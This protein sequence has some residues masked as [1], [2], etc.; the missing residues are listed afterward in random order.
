[1]AW[2]GKKKRDEPKEIVPDYRRKFYMPPEESKIITT[3][4]DFRIFKEKERKKLIWYEIL[5]QLAGKTIRMKPDTKTRKELESA[6]GFTGLQI[7]PED[8]MALII[9]TI[10]AFVFLTVILVGLGIVSMIASMFVI[11]IGV[12]IAYYF[13]KYPANLLKA[14]RIEASSQVVLAT[15]YMVV[16]MR[17]SPNLENA[18]R[19]AASNITGPLA[20]DMRRVIWDIEMGKYY[21]AA[22]AMTDYIAKWKAENEEFA[23][24]LRLIRDSRNQPPDRGEKVLDEALNIILDGTKVRMKHYAQDLSMP[25]MIIHMMGIVLPVLGSIM[26]PLAAIFLSDM[27]RPEYLFISYDVVLP[28]VIIWFINNTLKKR[29]STFSQV[30]I[31]KHP[32]VP[33]KGMFGMRMGKKT[34]MVPVLPIAI[35]VAF[36]FILPSIIFFSSNP[37]LLTSSQGEHTLE[38]LLMS[39]LIT[40]GIGLGLATYFI[41]SNYQKMSIQ[42][43]IYSIESE[44]ELALFQL[45]NRMSGGTPAE[46]AL[47]KSID[48]VKDLKISGLFTAAL[49][50]I[51]SL[52]ATFSEAFFH[53]KWGATKYYPS[54]LIENIMYMIVDIS[55]KGFMYAADGMLTVS[56]YLRNIRETQEYIRE[57]LSE[58][59]SSMTF[60]A[61]ILTP[62]ITGLIV[63]MS[64]VI[65]VVL[66]ILGQR[67]AALSSGDVPMDISGGLFGFGSNAES[68]ITPEIFQLVIGI[69]LIQVI[70]ILAIFLTKIGQDDNKTAQWY[71]AGKMLIIGL[72]A[73]FMIA[74]GTTVV[75]GDIIQ[76]TLTSVMG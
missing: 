29:P 57:L 21:S 27:I 67:L 8:V 47:E 75:F 37:N 76:E 17:I 58:S 19:F 39:C 40:M 23:E 49:R 5:C 38:S 68:G 42:G 33:P 28:L 11:V 45:G 22:D 20:W 12:G 69:Y 25:V 24:A 48:D 43:D 34:V 70:I 56:R 30:D 60:Q 63:A 4:R 55:R 51:K 61:Y 71:L 59:A 10:L 14:Y 73:Y 72:I 3:S 46:L 74:I 54:K 44:F 6:I 26:A 50:N 41:L 7:K 65:I 18:L 31:S 66:T 53:P 13:L 35:L 62:M 15:L 9:L 32:D 64:Q 36:M 16:S 52:G 1:M 2:F